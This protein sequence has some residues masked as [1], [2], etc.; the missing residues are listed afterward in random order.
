MTNVAHR[1]PVPRDMIEAPHMIHLDGALM[2]P[3]KDNDYTIEEGHIN[4]WNPLASDP[5]LVVSV[6]RLT[7]GARWAFSQEY[8]VFV[9]TRK[10]EHT[11]KN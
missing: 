9:D 4:W 10:N 1:H 7:D 5:C 8:G 2:Q 6:T 11:G 3:G